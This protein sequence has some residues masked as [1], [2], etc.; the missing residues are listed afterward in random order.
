MQ[1]KRGLSV[2]CPKPLGDIESPLAAIEDRSPGEDEPTHDGDTGQDRRSRVTEQ[3][4]GCDRTSE[5]GEVRH[6][7][8]DRGNESL[9]HDMG[10][11]DHDTTCE[12]HGQKKAHHGRSLADVQGDQPRRRWYERQCRRRASEIGTSRAPF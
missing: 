6:D 7:V 12:G 10:D 5:G 2:R 8:V 9:V 1:R 4:R 3:Y 11:S